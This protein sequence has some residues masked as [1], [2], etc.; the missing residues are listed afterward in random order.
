MQRNIQKRPKKVKRSI[1]V[2]TILLGI[3]LVADFFPAKGE[4]PEKAIPKQTTKP[5]WKIGYEW[6][7]K[8]THS[9]QPDKVFET[10]EK[11]IRKEKFKNVPCYVVSFSLGG[12]N[13]PPYV[14]GETYYTEDLNKKAGYMIEKESRY[15]QYECIPELKTFNWPL[16]VGKKWKVTYKVKQKIKNRYRK[17][18]VKGV[19]E[20]VGIEKIKVPAGEFQAFKIVLKVRQGK[21][22]VVFREWWYSPELRPIVKK[23]FY[24]EGGYIEEHQLSRYKL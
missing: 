1:A 22:M 15:L 21:K 20:I 7:Y 5:E 10:K 18:K 4:E 6:S 3:F 12:L 24:W 14:T 13:K 8:V 9:G 11:V 23:K 17:Y 16:E 2:L 19:V